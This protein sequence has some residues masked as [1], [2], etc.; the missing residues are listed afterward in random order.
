M[1]DA[2]EEKAAAVTESE[3]TESDIASFDVIKGIESQNE[4][5]TKNDEAKDEADQS[6]NV[7]LKEV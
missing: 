7:D 2:K 1:S 4:S 5:A 3:P 6:K